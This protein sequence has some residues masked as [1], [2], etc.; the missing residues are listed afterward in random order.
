MSLGSTTG[1]TDNHTTGIGI[2]V[3]STQANESRNQIY[4]AGIANLLCNPLGIRS[5]VNHT[6]TIT[7]PLNSGTSN[8]DGTLQCILNLAIQTPG[9]GGNQAILGIIDVIP[10]TYHTSARPTTERPL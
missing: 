9:D 4:T 2:P 3:W 5:R 7:E 8:E 6:G 10:D 1:N